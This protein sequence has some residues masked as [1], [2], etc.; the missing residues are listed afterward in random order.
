MPVVLL[1]VMFNPAIDALLPPSNPANPDADR[2]ANSYSG[3][4][5][6]K[7]GLPIANVYVFL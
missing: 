2:F 3:N 7:N 4:V 5:Y 1:F 6:R